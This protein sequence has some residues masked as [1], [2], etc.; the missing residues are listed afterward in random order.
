MRRNRQD[1]IEL[2]KIT[3]G[4][5]GVNIDDEF[6]L[7]KNTVR[8]STYLHTDS[9]VTADKFETTQSI[10]SSESCLYSRIYISKTKIFMMSMLVFLSRKRLKNNQ[11]R[12]IFI[13]TNQLTITLK[14][15]KVT[16]RS[17]AE[18]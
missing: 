16:D 3:K 4:L 1:L 14:L 7:E 15:K 8:K 12:K 2:F 18:R 17:T 13:N 6:I 10:T 5:S 9:A 11:P